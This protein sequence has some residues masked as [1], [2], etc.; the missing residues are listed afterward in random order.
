MRPWTTTAIIVLGSGLVSCIGDIYV[1]SKTLPGQFC[2]SQFEGVS[3]QLEDC[4]QWIRSGAELDVLQGTIKDIGWNDAYIVAWRK[5]NRGSIAAGWMVIDL[6]TRKVEGP[7][8]DAQLAAMRHKTPALANVK[9]LPVDEAWRQSR[10][11]RRTSG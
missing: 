10:G 4:S 2:I 7:L 8:T 6:S 5:P 11:S 3:Y 1:P 9:T